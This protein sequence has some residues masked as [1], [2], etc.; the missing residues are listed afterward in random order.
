MPSDD[1]T[2]P[3]DAGSH[4]QQPHAPVK[5]FRRLPPELR[6]EIWK[7]VWSAMARNL[8]PCQGRCPFLWTI[9]VMPQY[10]W[11]RATMNFDEVKVVEQKVQFIYIGGRGAP[12]GLLSRISQESR[13]FVLSK[14]FIPI[15][16]TQHWYWRYGKPPNCRRFRTPIRC[17]TVFWI[18]PKYDQFAVVY[19]PSHKGITCRFDHKWDGIIDNPWL[20]TCPVAL[21]APLDTQPS[22]VISLSFLRSLVVPLLWI[23]SDREGAIRMLAGLPCLEAISV[24]AEIQDMKKEDSGTDWTS[25]FSTSEWIETSL[26]SGLGT[27]D[28][29]PFLSPPNDCQSRLIEVLQ[30]LGS[31]GVRRA[32]I[33]GRPAH[34]AMVEWWRQNKL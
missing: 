13:H 28:L 29:P 1:D 16:A 8:D 22:R 5:G 4:S 26:R 7:L 3:D 10:P 19:Q 17:N 11:L 20:Q 24:I 32:N 23:K 27:W 15:S 14:G 6:L 31:K 34:L 25:V 9:H 2:H 21:T 12:I 30:F 18:N 33:V